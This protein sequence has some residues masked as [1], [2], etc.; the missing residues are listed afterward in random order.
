M[1]RHIVDFIII[2]SLQSFITL[3]RILSV[4]SA[5][6]GGVLAYIRCSASRR[7]ESMNVFMWFIFLS[8]YLEIKTESVP[9]T[10]EVRHLFDSFDIDTLWHHLINSLQ[11]EKEHGYSDDDYNHIQYH[12]R[13]V[14]FLNRICKVLYD[15]ST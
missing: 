12:I 15:W 9:V 8:F 7:S 10:I 5:G 14:F 4:K 1:V 3:F 13:C 2:C 6:G 11:S